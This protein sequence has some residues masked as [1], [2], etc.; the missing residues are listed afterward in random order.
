[1]GDTFF[2]IQIAVQAPPGDPWRRQL[3]QLVRGHLRDLDLRD[4]RGLHGSLANL[5]RAAIPRCS[6]GF[7]DLVPDGDAEFASWTSGIEDDSAEPWVPDRSG[8]VM[9]HVLVSAFCLVPADG[10]A[11]DLL[12]QRCD[13]PEAQWRRRAT[14][15]R[16][17]ETFAMLPFANVRNTAIYVT[18]GGDDL[19]FSRAELRG[20]GYDYLL[21]VES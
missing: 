8:A 3:V 5:L 14:W 13:L 17:F 18:P 4:E 7:W 19:A 15:L 2:G 6:L 9:D 12:G 20:P 16:L 21:P 1:M 11:A 10:A